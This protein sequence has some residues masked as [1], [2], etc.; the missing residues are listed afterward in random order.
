M[1]K[2]LSLCAFVAALSFVSCKQANKAKDAATDAVENVADEVKD[3]VE[4]IDSTANVAV[5]SLK[6]TVDTVAAAA[7]EVING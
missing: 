5:D 2:F 1:K 7:T 3:A 6:A 4:A